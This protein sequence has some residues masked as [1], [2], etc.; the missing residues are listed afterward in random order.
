MTEETK[1]AQRVDG[2]LPTALLAG[3]EIKQKHCYEN[4]DACLAVIG[5]NTIRGTLRVS[6]LSRAVQTAVG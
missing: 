4:T 6:T 3:W 1:Q 5:L 2:H